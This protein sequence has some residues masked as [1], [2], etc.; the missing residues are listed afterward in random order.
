MIDDLSNKEMQIYTGMI[1]DI[2]NKEMQVASCPLQVGLFA[3]LCN[4]N[5]LSR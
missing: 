3:I 5:N 4:E 2:S 1:D